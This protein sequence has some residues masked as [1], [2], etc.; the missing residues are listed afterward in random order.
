MDVVGHPAIANGSHA[1]TTV[2]PVALPTGAGRA[3]QE[4]RRSVSPHNETAPPSK[5]M[6]PGYAE[7]RAYLPPG[8]AATGPLCPLDRLSKMRGDLGQLRISAPDGAHTRPSLTRPSC[9]T[10]RRTRSQSSSRPRRPMPGWSSQG[11][12]AP[13][14]VAGHSK[15]SLWTTLARGGSSSRGLG[16]CCSA[17]TDASARRSEDVLAK[18]RPPSF[19]RAVECLLGIHRRRRERSR[20]RGD[21]GPPTPEPFK[22]GLFRALFGTPEWYSI[23]TNLV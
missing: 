5:L 10:A 15:P 20:T 22:S 3:L 17:R 18:R 13:P 19:P 16:K 2:I 6:S 12:F 23:F 9:S 8:A 1:R 14:R 4:H 21:V 11:G 7:R